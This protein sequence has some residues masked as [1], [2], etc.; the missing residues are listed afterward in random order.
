MFGWIA[1]LQMDMRSPLEADR[2]G[3]MGDG[4]WGCGASPIDCK[5]A[6]AKA[7]PRIEGSFRRANGSS[8]LP[9]AAAGA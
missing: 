2:Q 5:A 9:P 8:P 7:A 6:F 3:G 4:R 1:D